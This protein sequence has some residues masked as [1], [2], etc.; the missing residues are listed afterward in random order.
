MR[1]RCPSSPYLGLAR[2]KKYH[3]IINERGYAN[4]VEITSTASS[5]AA[6]DEKDVV[7]GLVYALNKK[8]EAQLDRNEGVPK[9]YTKEMLEV[10]FWEK[11]EEGKALDV[12]KKPETRKMLV[13]INRA[14]TS[15]KFKAKEEYV[16]R[17]NMGIA[18]ALKEGVPRTYVEKVLR[19]WIPEEEEE[20]AREVGVG[21]ETRNATARALAEKQAKEFVEEDDRE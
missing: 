16:H 9:A 18:D 15:G 3:W 20:N 4:V 5:S 12:G 19:H 13:Y 2:L 11:G 14:L 10:E 6:D 7:W 1:H 17:M 8:D 21:G